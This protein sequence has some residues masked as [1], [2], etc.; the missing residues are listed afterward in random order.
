MTL[1]SHWQWALQ[2]AARKLWLTALF[3][4]V[5]ALVS[6]G[7][8]ILLAPLIP[9]FAVNYVTPDAVDR[10]LGILASSML[11]VTTFSLATM[12]TA[13]GVVS[14]STSPRAATLVLDNEVTRHALG[15]FIGSFLFSLV[16]LVALNAGVYSERGHVL[17][18]AVTG[19]V[20]VLIVVALLRWI[21]HLSR[22]ARVSEITS[23]VEQAALDALLERARHPGLGA[24]LCT[25]LAA[26]IPAGSRTICTRSIGYIQHVDID[27]LVE[28]SEEAGV[29]LFVAAPP[30]TFVDL[31]SPLV[32]V[33]G[34][35]AEGLDEDAL[36]T[37]F[38]IGLNRTFD[39]DPRLGLIVLAEIASRAL[40][41][42]I[43]DPGTAIDQIG[44]AI[45]VLSL[46]ATAEPESEGDSGAEP[47]PGVWLEAL[48]ADDLMDDVFTP[49]ARDGAG[50][51]AVQIRLQKALAALAGLGHAPLRRAALR[52]SAQAWERAREAMAMPFDR[53]ALRPVVLAPG[54]IEA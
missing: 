12:V 6:V 42:G 2:Q 53:E 5:A 8:G 3:Y 47:A 9:D 19:V 16:G 48:S 54:G 36:R 41:P 46:W 28:L 49:I 37:A 40:S 33:A 24:G 29:E 50:T 10:V 15:V 34:D 31:N 39:H 18:F 45:R 17:L 26:R 51:L 13:H 4:V 30:G 25:D 43:N 1:K 23:R 52:H 20:I 22:L 7:I 11:A 38:S 14:G 27:A 35:G 44:R 32:K 21:D